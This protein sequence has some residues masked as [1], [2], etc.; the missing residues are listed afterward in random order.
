MDFT[1]PDIKALIRRAIIGVLFDY[2]SYMASG[3]WHA[4]MIDKL[5][6]EIHARLEQK[7]LESW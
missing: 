2:N 1:D 5:T 7:E 3:E 6:D 4:E